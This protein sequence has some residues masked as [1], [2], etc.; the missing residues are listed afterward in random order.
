MAEGLV[1]MGARRG[2]DD[3]DEDEL[4][5]HDLAWVGPGSGIAG[6]PKFS[7][8][9]R[10]HSEAL[11]TFT[12]EFQRETGTTGNLPRVPARNKMIH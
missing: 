8:V 2:G 11:G 10:I 1:L 5:F 6:T 12:P 9:F 4:L 3:S 7:K